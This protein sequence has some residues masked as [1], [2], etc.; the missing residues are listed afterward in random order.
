M[1]FLMGFTTSVFLGSS[2]EGGFHLPSP[3]ASAGSTKLSFLAR[4]T[5]RGR[6]KCICVSDEII[7]LVDAS[8]L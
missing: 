2:Y 1:S 8:Y 4:T 3:G 6:T 5:T 7:L